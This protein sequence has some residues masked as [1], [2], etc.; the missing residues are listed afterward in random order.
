M[1]SNISE[2]LKDYVE[3]SVRN[4]VDKPEEVKISCTVSTKL[5]IIQIETAAN[6]RGKIIGK[7]GRIIDALK[8]IVSAMKNARFPNDPKKVALEII[9]DENPN[10]SYLEGRGGNRNEVK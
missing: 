2:L 5:V 9:E 6:D 8:I 10:L 4:L 7:G 3:Q 1:S